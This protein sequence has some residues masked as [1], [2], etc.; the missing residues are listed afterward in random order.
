MKNKQKVV[1]VVVL[2]IVAGFVLWWVYNNEGKENKMAK[3]ENSDS[4]KMMLEMELIAYSH[5]EMN[6]IRLT[7]EEVNAKIKEGIPF[8]LYTGR[9]TCQWC[10][11]MVPI[12]NKV[13][14]EDNIELFYLDSENTEE[15]EVLSDFRDKFGIKTVPSIIYFKGSENYYT[16]ELNVTENDEDEIEINL[17]EQF[18]AAVKE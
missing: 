5:A 16:F 12:L 1:A 2:I 7:A 14:K 10:R 3:E 9:A 6:F 11:K 13:I 18:E 15:D 17:K 8:F 4:T